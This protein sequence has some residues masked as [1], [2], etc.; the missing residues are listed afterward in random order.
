VSSSLYNSRCRLICLEMRGRLPREIDTRE[1]ENFAQELELLD[2][3]WIKW[4][5]YS[6][7]KGATIC[8]DIR[9]RGPSSHSMSFTILNGEAATGCLVGCLTQVRISKEPMQIAIE[10]V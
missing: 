10:V 6:G 7:P 8:I 3:V 9:G 2:V 1:L 4:I 5:K